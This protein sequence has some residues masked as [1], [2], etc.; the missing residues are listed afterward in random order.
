MITAMPR[1]AIAVRDMDR[2]ITT[3]GDRLGM[4]V[5]EFKWVREDLG[6]RMALCVPAGGSH[7]ELMS[8]EDPER[9]WKTRSMFDRYDIKNEDDLR[10]AAAQVATVRDK[11]A[12]TRVTGTNAPIS[13][14]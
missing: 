4:P 2:A 6:I 1:I 9:A 11:G 5:H 3:F 10:E 13:T 14:R 8:P 7:I 12:K